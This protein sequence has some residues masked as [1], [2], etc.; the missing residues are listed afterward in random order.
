MAVVSGAAAEAFVA[1]IDVPLGVEVSGPSADGQWLVR[2]ADHD[3]LADLL[4]AT[5][6]PAGRLRL[7]VDPVRL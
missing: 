3:Q 7:S 5:P 4:A 2:A 6:R 1:A